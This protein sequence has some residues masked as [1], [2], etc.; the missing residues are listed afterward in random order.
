MEALKIVLDYKIFIGSS[1]DMSEVGDN[2]VQLVVTSPPYH[3]LVVFSEGE[4]EGWKNDLSRIKSEDEFFERLGKVWKECFRVTKYG[5]YLVCEWE[6]NPVGSRIYGYPREL[7]YA[8]PMIKSIEDAGFHL[9]SR[10]YWKK[11]EAGAVVTKFQYTLHSH[12][13]SSDPRA[14]ANV[15][16][17]FVFKKGRGKRPKELDF[18]KKEWTIWCDGLWR[19]ENPS[20]SAG[21]LSAGAIFPDELVRRLIKI[22]SSPEELVLDPFLGTG[23]TMKVAF[24]LDRSCIGYEALARMLPYIRKKVSYGSTKIFSN[25]NWSITKKEE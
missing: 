4:E 10:W 8:G 21:G 9:I 13:T 15:A 12:L 24:G 16:Y 2:T 20:T 23:T 3:D 22:Y 19:I 5:G 7:C 6:D 18:T 17:V 11:F 14:I 25:I 1:E